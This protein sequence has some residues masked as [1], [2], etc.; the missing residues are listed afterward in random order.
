MLKEDDKSGLKKDQRVAS[1]KRIEIIIATAL[2][3]FSILYF[4]GTLQ[5][6]IGSLK[7]PGPG[8]IPLVIG[9]FL[10]FFTGL[11]NVQ[12]WRGLR[13]RNLEKR[14]Q[15][16][17]QIDIWSYIK[18]YGTLACALAY[19]FLLENLKFIIATTVVT[20]F[21][22]FILRPQKLFLTLMLAFLIVVFSFW[23]F[24]I[25]LGVSF[26]FGPLEELFFRWLW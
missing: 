6:K 21:L 26:P 13:K 20:F 17:R 24:A 1:E 5:L 12:L 22:L 15:V 19:P 16:G 9:V 11:Y 25:L 18:I 14:P 23:I 8:L 2:S 3:G 10:L 7:N 4:L